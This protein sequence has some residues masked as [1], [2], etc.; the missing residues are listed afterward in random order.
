MELMM[1]AGVL[2]VENNNYY[3]VDDTFGCYKKVDKKEFI[4]ELKKMSWV[5]LTCWDKKVR[6]DYLKLVDYVNKKESE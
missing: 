6:D 2:K 5:C 4:E 3:I 1:D